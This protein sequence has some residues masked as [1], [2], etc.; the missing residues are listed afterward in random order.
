MRIRYT[1]YGRT[2][3]IEIDAYP[4]RVGI[5]PI[6]S[7]L[8]YDYPGIA[9]AWG[10][11]PCECGYTDGTVD[12]EHKSASDMIADAWSYLEEHEGE[13]ARDP[14]YFTTSG[15]QDEELSKWISESA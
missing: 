12:C 2:G 1:L 13:Y 6:Y 8:D 4:P 7:Q 11:V 5:E 10:Y 14:G 9:S 15:W 3:G